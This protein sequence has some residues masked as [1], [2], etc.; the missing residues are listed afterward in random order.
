MS[1]KID[2]LKPEDLELFKRYAVDEQDEVEPVSEEFLEESVLHCIKV[3]GS[4]FSAVKSMRR[5]YRVT[6]ERPDYIL[7]QKM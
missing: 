4:L 6:P 7:T 5:W 2:L 1:R 3:Q